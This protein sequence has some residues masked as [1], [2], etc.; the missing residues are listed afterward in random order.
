MH[1][2]RYELSD[3]FGDS[4]SCFALKSEERWSGA[5]CIV[6]SI[7]Q[8]FLTGVSRLIRC[9]WLRKAKSDFNSRVTKPC[10]KLQLLTIEGWCFLTSC[11]WW[12]EASCLSCIRLWCFVTGG[13]VIT[14][15]NDDVGITAISYWHIF[16]ASKHCT[17]Q[18]DTFTYT[19]P[20]NSLVILLWILNLVHSSVLSLGSYKV[21]WV[22]RSSS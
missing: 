18:I 12:Q 4:L 1:T 9:N 6:I 3:S 20:H 11:S 5:L 16:T 7:S 19:I 21:I 8:V 17:R 22:K 15:D 10:I 2:P 14:S 13:P